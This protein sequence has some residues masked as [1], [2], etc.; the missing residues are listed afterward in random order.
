MEV[1]YASSQEALSKANLDMKAGRY[2]VAL[3][4]LRQL[5]NKDKNDYQAWF[6]LG[7]AYTHDRRYYQAIEAFRQVIA[8]RPDLAE[9]HNNLADL[10]VKLALEHYRNSMEKA[11]N[12]VVQQ[13]YTRL[14]NVLKSIKDKTESVKGDVHHSKPQP[15]VVVDTKAGQSSGYKAVAKTENSL[16]ASTTAVDAKEAGGR[17]ITF[18]LDALETWRLVWSNQNVDKYFLAY[19][20]NFKPPPRFSS[21][22]SWK[23]YKRKAINNKK[24][25]HVNFEQVE[26]DIQPGGNLATVMMLQ[27]FRSNSYNADDF[28]KITMKYQRNAWKIIG[29]TTVK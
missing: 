13:R 19:A 25:I 1:S 26:V 12:P 10:Y 6:L 4:G 23:K 24:F 21:L 17:S 22:K 16:I 18:V 2:S 20:A 7:V 8:L 5:V 3:E 27:H 15:I 29:E 11:P 14:L 9:P 28:K